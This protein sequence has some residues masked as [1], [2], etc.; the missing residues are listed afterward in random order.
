MVKFEFIEDAISGVQV[1]RWLHVHARN[2]LLL[3]CVFKHKGAF[4]VYLER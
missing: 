1:H 3:R 4:V 2:C